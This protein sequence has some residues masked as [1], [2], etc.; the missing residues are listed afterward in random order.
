MAAD[1]DIYAVLLEIK[2]DMG[3]LRSDIRAHSD[4]TDTAIREIKQDSVQGC[5]LA[6]DCKKRIELL[7]TKVGRI[8]VAVVALLVT[9]FGAKKLVSALIR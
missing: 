7:D 9:V 1:E 4:R 5:R 6:Q 3:E 8:T 2:E